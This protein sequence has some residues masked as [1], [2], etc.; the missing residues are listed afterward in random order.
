MKTERVISGVTLLETLL[1]VFILTIALAPLAVNQVQQGMNISKQGLFVHVAHTSSTILNRMLKE[2]S[3]NDIVRDFSL[4]TG[5]ALLPEISVTNLLTLRAGSNSVSIFDD[6]KL[7]PPADSGLSF[8]SANFTYYSYR[9]EGMNEDTDTSSAHKIY[10]SMKIER[11]HRD[12]NYYENNKDTPDTAPAAAQL[13]TITNHGN[14]MKITLIAGWNENIV[15]HE[16]ESATNKRQIRTAV[17]PNYYSL[18]TV[19]ANLSE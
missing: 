7:Q 18:V 5:E 13:K 10:Y 1:A 15:W 3:F 19:K 6:L 8:G 9:D 17:K 2:T 12:F 4:P 14:L 11:F 16:E